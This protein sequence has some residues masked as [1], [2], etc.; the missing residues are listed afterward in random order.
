MLYRSHVMVCGGTGCTS[1]NSDRIAKC[2]EEEI[3][4]KG[5]DKDRVKY[6]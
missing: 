6:F 5:L 1:S 4:S 3:A 2:F